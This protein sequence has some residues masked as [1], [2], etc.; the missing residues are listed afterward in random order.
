MNICVSVLLEDHSGKKSLPIPW[1]RANFNIIV[2]AIIDSPIFPCRF[3]SAV[4]RGLQVQ[5][6]DLPSIYRSTHFSGNYR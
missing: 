6:H 5:V 2:D 3:A 4:V 1:L